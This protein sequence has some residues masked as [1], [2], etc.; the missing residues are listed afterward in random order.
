MNG[1]GSDQRALTHG[2][3][4]Y[5][6]PSTADDGTLVATDELG[7]LHR[8]ARDGAALGPPIPTAAT[9]A[10]E[11]VPAETPTHVRLSPDGSADRLRPADRRRPDHAVDA[12][13]R[14]RP[15]LPRPGARP[16]GLQRAVLDRQRPAR[17]QPR[18]H[19]RRA[20][21]GRAVRRRQRRQQRGAVVRRRRQRLGDRVRRGRLARRDA[22]RGA[23]GRR[24]R[25]RRRSRRASSCACSP[26]PG[27]A[28]LRRSAASWRSRRRTR[29]ALASPTFSPDGSRIAWAESDGIHAATLGALDDCGAIR[30]QILTLPGAWEP[31]WSA[32]PAPPAARRRAGVAEAHARRQHPLA[33]AAGVAAPARPGGARDDQRARHGAAVGAR[34]GQEEALRGR[35]HA[36][37][38]ERGHDDGPRADARGRGEVGEAARAARERP[39]RDAGR[40]RARPR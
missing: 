9:V 39:G 18:R 15:E 20:V 3:Q 28:R 21:A 5:E 14:D 17:A 25:Q 27:R 31:H 22:D 33:A 1:D 32:A 11:D 29:Y 38:G 7:R 30:E 26:R 36:Q 12:R 19:L 40:G 8:L 23:G 10:T 6:W 16:A 35:D 2:E 37:A 13:D 34:R 24:R 4:R